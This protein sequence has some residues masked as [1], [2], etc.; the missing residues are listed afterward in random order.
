MSMLPLL[1]RTPHTPAALTTTRKRW[2]TQS[3]QL[4]AYIFLYDRKILNTTTKYICTH[5]T[6]IY[7]QQCHS[8]AAGE[9]FTLLVIL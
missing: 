4:H 8:G 3:P 7:R 6:T 1:T 5:T 2:R 9:R